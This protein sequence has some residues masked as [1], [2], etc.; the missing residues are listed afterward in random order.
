MKK[1]EELRD[2]RRYFAADSLTLKTNI[3]SP[4]N[5]VSG[6]AYPGD[7]FLFFEQGPWIGIESIE[8]GNVNLV[9]FTDVHFVRLPRKP[10]K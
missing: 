5:G 2:D 6:A 7:Q 3:P 8:T 10:K 4:R 1:P 9:P